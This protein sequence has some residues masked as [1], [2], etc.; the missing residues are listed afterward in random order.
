MTWDTFENTNP[1]ECKML[2]QN[3]MIASNVNNHN[4]MPDLVQN[5]YLFDILTIM[6]WIV[7]EQLMCSEMEA[8]PATHVALVVLLLLQTRW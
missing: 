6:L 2:K 5:N 1:I 4:N 7:S 3:K 8:V